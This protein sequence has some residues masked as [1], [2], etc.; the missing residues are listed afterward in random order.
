DRGPETRA[1]EPRATAQ[2]DRDRA[3]PSRTHAALHAQ[4][5]GQPADAFRASREARVLPVRE[6]AESQRKSERKNPQGDPASPLSPPVRARR[7]EHG[8]SLVPGSLSLAREAD[9]WE[10]LL[11]VAGLPQ[12]LVRG[13]LRRLAVDV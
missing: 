3:K 7:T 13:L 9:L 1:H 5:H 4:P 6:S 11:D 12:V 2:P 10:G 8:T